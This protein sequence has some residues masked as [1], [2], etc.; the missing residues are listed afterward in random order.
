[1]KSQVLQ[2]YASE[3]DITQMCAAKNLNPRILHLTALNLTKALIPKY[4][5]SAPVKL[6]CW[7][8]YFSIRHLLVC[9]SDKSTCFVTLSTPSQ[10]CFVQL[11]CLFSYFLHFLPFLCNAAH[12]NALQCHRTY[13]PQ[14]VVI[15]NPEMSVVK[16]TKY[17]KISQMFRCYISSGH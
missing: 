15:F 7:A 10:C 6:N 3:L 13:W 11:I 1:M 14:F 16:Y 2:V 4:K 5:Y 9:I 17:K 12:T 8:S